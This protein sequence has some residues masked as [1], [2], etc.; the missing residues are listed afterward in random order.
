MK[1][2]I[3]L[4]LSLLALNAFSAEYR[5]QKVKHLGIMKNKVIFQGQDLQKIK[6]TNVLKGKLVVQWG[7]HVFEV[8]NGLYACNKNNSCKLTDFERVATFKS[9]VVKSKT[10][11]ECRK[12]ISGDSS[13]SQE[14]TVQDDPDRVSDEFAN[15]R[16]NDEYSEFPVRVKDEFDGIF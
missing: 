16:Y 4:I 2:I 12:K 3:A 11:V 13:P 6:R 14:I 9:C 15:E 7:L 8:V 5:V 1:L 10:K